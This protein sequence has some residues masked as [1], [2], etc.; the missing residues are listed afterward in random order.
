MGSAVVA[1]SSIA[2]SKAEFI[3]TTLSGAKQIIGSLST[4]GNLRTADGYEM[5]LI[6]LIAY[7]QGLGLVAQTNA[8]GNCQF[9]LLGS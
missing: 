1:D 8:Q 3:S 6:A 7:A 5:R 2:A 9:S 4:Q